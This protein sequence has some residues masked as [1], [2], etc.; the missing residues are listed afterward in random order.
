MYHGFNGWTRGNRDIDLFMHLWEPGIQA[1]RSS[2]N[3]LYF[4][5][6]R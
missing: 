3:S 1:D 4:F 6:L 5:S 2:N